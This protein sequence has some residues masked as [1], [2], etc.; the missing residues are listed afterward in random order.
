[1]DLQNRLEGNTPL[2]AAVKNLKDP[3]ER[4]YVVESLLE[5]GAD[6]K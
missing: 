6:T 3:E 2:H 1:M 5:A 4:N